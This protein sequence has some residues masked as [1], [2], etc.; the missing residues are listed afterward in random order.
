MAQFRLQIHFR[1]ELCHLN[2]ALKI[3]AVGYVTDSRDAS[4]TSEAITDI[5]KGLCTKP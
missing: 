2:S 4:V 3:Q 5:S 1:S